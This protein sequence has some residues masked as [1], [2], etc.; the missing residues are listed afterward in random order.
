MRIKL[1]AFYLPQFHEIPE[2]N[3]WWGKGFTEWDNV[4]KARSLYRTHNQPRYPLNNNYYDLLDIETMKW[5]ADLAKKY[6][7]YGFCFYHYWFGGKKLL[8][9]PIENLLRNKD[10]NINFC[11]SWANEPWTRTWHGAAGE[12]EILIRQEYGRHDEWMEHFE[13]LLEFF[14]DK[15]YIKKD[16]KP[17]FLI[18]RT[19]YMDYC[20]DML[21][22]WNRLAIENG[23]AGIHFVNMLTARDK[24]SKSKYLEA[25]VDFEPGR[26][27][28]ERIKK[29][30]RF[31]LLK[32]VLRDKVKSLGVFNRLICN[33]VD[34][35]KINME[36]L[37]KKHKKSEYR[38]VF[39]DYDDTPRRGIKGIIIKGSTP[40]S[41]GKYLSENIRRSLNEGNDYLFINAWN[42]WGESNYLEPDKRYGYAYLRAVRKALVD[43]KL[44]E[45]MKE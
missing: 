23:F 25:T 33:I 32:N 29:E 38:G 6:G 24:Y 18:Y 34:Y 42:E 3:K 12:K 13:Y 26:T 16:N 5:Q 39:V 40:A 37:D 17:I 35:D 11:L 36:M 41:F 22:L 14:R 9:K 44:E 19:G 2:N 10:I 30:E 8:E 43:N 4:K 7:I 27:R 20:N 28:R 31:S 21:E 15:R 1:I 45:G